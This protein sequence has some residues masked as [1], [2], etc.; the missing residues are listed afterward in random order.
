MPAKPNKPT[1]L[2]VRITVGVNDKDY[3]SELHYQ[4]VRYVIDKDHPGVPKQQG[5]ADVR[6][7]LTAAFGTTVVDAAYTALLDPDGAGD[8][9]HE[10]L[11]NP[12]MPAP[13]YDEQ[14]RKIDAS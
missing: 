10:A 8:A 1:K 13:G 5:A 9:I 11:A 12:E 2:V 6:A 7:M 4:S 14:T 3:G